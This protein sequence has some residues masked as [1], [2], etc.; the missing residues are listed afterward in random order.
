MKMK[1]AQTLVQAIPNWLLWAIFALIAVLA[2]IFLAAK[3]L[4]VM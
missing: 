3:I 2:L 1:K 4:G